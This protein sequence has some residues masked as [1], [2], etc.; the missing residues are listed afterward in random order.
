MRDPLDVIGRTAFETGPGLVSF[1]QGPL[2]SKMKP[3]GAHG[4]RNKSP[5]NFKHGESEVD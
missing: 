3:I 5:A 4:P 1:T 2:H